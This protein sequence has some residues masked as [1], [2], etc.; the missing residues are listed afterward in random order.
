M[1]VFRN[2]KCLVYCGALPVIAFIAAVCWWLTDVNLPDSETDP[3]IFAIKRGMT[4]SEIGKELHARGIIRNVF[5]FN[6]VARFY[7]L[8]RDFK[9]GDHVL[10]GKMSLIR[11]A[12]LLT[13]NP[14][15]PEIKVTIIEGLNIY[16]TASLLACQAGIDSIAFVA[17]AKDSSIT[18]N[19]GV[20]NKTLEGYLYPETYFI[21]PDTTPLQMITRM[22]NQFNMVFTDSLKKRASELGMSINDV[23][24][25]ASLIE[26]EAHIKEERP[27]ISSVFHKRLKK[28]WPLEANPTI[29]YALGTKRRI[30]NDDLKILSP[31]NTYV[32]TGLPPGPIANPGI[33]SLLAALYPAETDYLYF[34]ADGKGGHVFSRTLDEHTKA[35]HDYRITKKT[36]HVQ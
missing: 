16:E 13:Q 19:L 24:I 14:P 5:F 17:S 26:A 18:K 8:S 22:V 12:R 27:I 32:Y 9:A 4:T 15:E 35:V 10:Y 2:K 28:N 33:Q 11:L 29:Q 20:D 34:V 1:T 25:L 23:V 36:S 30:L 7:G 3:C 6:M 31:Y 21:R